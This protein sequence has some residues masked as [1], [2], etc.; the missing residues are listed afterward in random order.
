MF[1]QKIALPFFIFIIF[2]GAKGFAEEPYNKYSGT[3]I[4]DIPGYGQNSLKFPTFEEEMDAYFSKKNQE[5]ASI[6]EKD[7]QTYGYIKD[8]KTIYGFIEYVDINLKDDYDTSNKSINKYIKD[9]DLDK[10]SSVHSQNKKLLEEM[11]NVIKNK[12]LFKKLY[13][14]NH[15][16]LRGWNTA[17]MQFSKNTQVVKDMVQAEGSLLLELKLASPL[18]KNQGINYTAG[19]MLNISNKLTIFKGTLLRYVPL[20]GD[21]TFTGYDAYSL[22]QAEKS[23][24]IA[25]HSAALNDVL[26]SSSGLL[27]SLAALSG[28]ITAPVAAGAG[29]IIGVT[30]LASKYVIMP[31]VFEDAT[32]YQEF[33]DKATDYIYDSLK[34]HQISYKEIFD[35]ALSSSDKKNEIEKLNNK[36]EQILSYIQ[37]EAKT[38][39]EDPS[40]INR[41]A[42]EQNKDTIL[43]SID[44]SRKLSSKLSQKINSSIYF[45]YTKPI[46]LKFS[47]HTEYSMT[48]KV[49]KE[50]PIYMSGIMQNQLSAITI[51]GTSHIGS[52]S[53]FTTYNNQQPNSCVNPGNTNN[54][55]TPTGSLQTAYATNTQAFKS[56][57]WVMVS[58]DPGIH[59]AAGQSFGP[60]TAPDGGQISSLNNSNMQSTVMTK[61][62]Q[63]PV[64]VKQVTLTFNG[65]FVTNEYPQYVGSQYNDYATVKITSPSGNV[66]AVTAFEQ[67]LNSS[68]FTAVSGLP[69]PMGSDGGHTGF[70]PS[71]ATINV[72]GGG[73]VTVEVSVANVGD[74]A[75]PSAVLLNSVTVK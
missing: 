44:Y 57:D 36:L 45:D 11:N 10:L 69:T 55:Q 35:S 66:T 53:L 52:A 70:K 13:L 39:A 43:K 7:S 73:K 8:A 71:T 75:V 47:A 72:A 20:I 64:G 42:I 24:D 58:G 49:V 31:T 61:D 30:S 3:L 17:Y 18:A 41:Q 28:I 67:K 6:N 63:V 34:E 50:E 32:T 62:F 37:K 26:D 12:D 56:S 29:T 60:I 2:F 25:Q 48:Y 14:E 46:E 40:F 74:T 5:M 54:Y 22:K 51:G 65:N 59:T 1:T 21:V 15:K 4:T 38:R 16:D 68:N 19:K 9:L 23:G 33:T 27:L